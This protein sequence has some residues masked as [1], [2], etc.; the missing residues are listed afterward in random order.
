MQDWN[1]AA[2]KVFS[3]FSASP[4]RIWPALLV[5]G[6]VPFAR[7]DSRSKSLADVGSTVFTAVER[8]RCSIPYPVT[9]FGRNLG[10]ARAYMK[11]QAVRSSAIR[12]IG[13]DP[14]ERILEVEFTDD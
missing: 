6:S 7:S 14:R 3:T 1:V 10:R 13:Y 8:S 5:A 11:R 4:T 2:S 9:L 12:S